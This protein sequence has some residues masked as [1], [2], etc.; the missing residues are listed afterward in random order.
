[1]ASTTPEQ[2]SLADVDF[3]QQ[4]AAQIA[5]AVANMTA[6]EEIAALEGRMSWPRSSAWTGSSKGRAGRRRSSGCIP[7]RSGVA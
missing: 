6:Y 3:L 4:A 7:I 5:L 1:V 2:Y